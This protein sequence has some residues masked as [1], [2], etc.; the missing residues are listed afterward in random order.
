MKRFLMTMVF[1]AVFMV[2]S[3]QAANGKIYFADSA[4]LSI[5]DDLDS[6]GLNTSFS[7]EYNVGDA[8]GYDMS[9]FRVGSV[10]VDEVNVIGSPIDS[11]IDAGAFGSADEEDLG[12]QFRW[13]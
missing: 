12:Y 13:S 6:P 11:E 8:L 7:P 9:R 2:N 1:A 4:E 10:E 5:T 3:A